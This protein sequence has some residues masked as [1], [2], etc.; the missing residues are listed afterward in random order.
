MTDKDHGGDRDS[1]ILPFVAKESNE[2]PSES[3]T[4]DGEVQGKTEMSA[5]LDGMSSLEDFGL[6]ESEETAFLSVFG[7]LLDSD[8]ETDGPADD[9]ADGLDEFDGFVE[10]EDAPNENREDQNK[11]LSR[12]ANGKRPR[13]V[14][15]AVS[16]ERNA[17]DDVPLTPE[18]LFEAMLFVGDRDNRPLSPFRAAE[19]MRNVEPGEIRELVERLN[20]RYAR[21]SRPYRIIEDGDGFR[22]VLD[23]AFDS[24]RAR[25]YG[26]I[27]EA[28]LSQQAID[29]LAVV[30]YR[31]PISAEEVQAVRKTPSGSVLT[32]LVRR[33]LLGIE[34]KTESK[35]PILFYR[36]TPRFLELFGLDSL[37]DLPMPEEIEFR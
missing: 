6:S 12:D 9:F 30:A 24:I 17:T 22:M 36:T 27:R 2:K 4:D 28:K 31:Q 3:G 11:D 23:S 10:E 21:F 14:L 7:D 26:K 35:K 16:C 34:R 13:N 20:E 33:G 8:G 1:R 25:F 15:E 37:D 18:T 29:V 32:Q 19:L 5:N